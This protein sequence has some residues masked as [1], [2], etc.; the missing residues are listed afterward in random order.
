MRTIRA[1]PVLIVLCAWPVPSARV[2]A[3]CVTIVTSPEQRLTGTALV[4]VADVLSIEDVVRPESYRVRVRF[5][6][7]EAYRGIETGE[8]TVSFRP[9]AEEFRFEVG[10]RVLVYA[11]GTPED[12]STACSHTRVV[13]LQDREVQELRR[14]ARK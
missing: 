1:L 8:R 4:F 12:Y 11:G 13:T 5:H 10:R 3:E 2:A 9:T 7:I 14:L 6:V